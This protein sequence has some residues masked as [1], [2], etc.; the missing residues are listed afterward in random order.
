MTR[1]LPERSSWYMRKPP[2]AYRIEPTSPMRTL[3]IAR[4]KMPVVPQ[5]TPLSEQIV[6]TLLLRAKTTGSAMRSRMIPMIARIQI[7]NPS[8]FAATLSLMGGSAANGGSVSM[9]A[10]DLVVL[11]IVVIQVWLAALPGGQLPPGV[12]GGFLRN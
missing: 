5:L 11:P 7:T 6:L 1:F 8:V 4:P 9:L 12:V 3:M 2:K 10:M